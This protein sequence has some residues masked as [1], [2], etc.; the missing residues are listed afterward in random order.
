MR[1]RFSTEATDLNNQA[2]NR[3]KRESKYYWDEMYKLISA[4]G[5][6]YMEVPYEGKWDFGGRSGIPRTL[7]SIRIKFGSMENYRKV[8]AK[9]GIAGISSVHMDPSL[10]CSGVM[11]MYFGA[12]G[13][14]AEEAIEFAG[15][16]EA[17]SITFTATPC[18]HA[19]HALMKD[20]AQTTEAGD[21]LFLEKTKELIGS[22]AARADKAGVK[23]CLKNEYW[24][25]L[26]G[27][28]IVPFVKEF[29]GKVYLDVDTAHLQIAGVDVKKFIVENKDLIGTVHFTDTSFVDEQD[30]YLQALPEYPAK[31]AAKVFCDLGEGTVDFAGIRDLLEENGYGGQIICLC[32]DSYDVSRSLLRSRYVMNSLSK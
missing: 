11:E 19:V 27:E 12:F 30:A 24:G 16:A 2:P 15:Q 8:L 20:R 25:L 9:A 4:A 10:F 31:A 32:K 3:K 1:E 29:S 28:A 23:L 18:I 21:A 22:L 17:E 14:Y 26:R 6:S 5:F 7:R 13:H